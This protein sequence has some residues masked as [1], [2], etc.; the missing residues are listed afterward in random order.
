[1]SVRRIVS[2]SAVW[3]VAVGM[4]ALTPISAMGQTPANS[5]RQIIS[6]VA[7]TKTGKTACSVQVVDLRTGQT[8]YQANPS[9]ALAP[10][11]NMKVLTT[12][13]A[14][15]LLGPDYRYH[16][17]FGL[18]DQSLVVYASGDPSINDPEMV[19]QTNIVD[20]IDRLAEKLTEPI[21]TSATDAQGLPIATTRALPKAIVVDISVFDRQYR[22]PGWPAR[23]L[24][25]WFTAPVTA[26]NINDNCLDLYAGPGADRKGF[27]RI[28]PPCD[29]LKL[30][31]N[32]LPKGNANTTITAR[33][34]KE[35]WSLI[36]SVGVGS[37]PTGP[38]WVVINDPPALFAQLLKHRLNA[39]GVPIA[40]EPTFDRMRQPN[41]EP[42]EGFEPMLEYV[43]PSLADIITR[44]NKNSQNLFAE[45]LFKTVGREFAGKVAPFA[46][47][48][49]ST[50]GLAVKDFLATEVRVPITELEIHDGSGL[51]STNR[52]TAET[53]VGTLKYCLRQ[54]WAKAY[55]NSMAI[56]GKDGTMRR[57]LR[58]TIGDQRVYAKTG[59]I[60]NVTSLSGYVMDRSGEPAAAFS[61]LFNGDLSGVRA[62]H[63]QVCLE[64]V[65]YVDQTAT[66]ARAER[67]GH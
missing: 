8:L 30:N 28:D 22:H 23:D 24:G 48:S 50:G 21:A 15:H 33:W 67:I 10:A 40:T 1:M 16:T 58:R 11:S 43:S 64:L 27:L 54:P 5:I 19:Q 55:I 20:V 3:A 26:M 49:W 17:R 42:T 9:L 6:S 32:Y 7:G 35:E 14:M 62:A 59:Y 66:Q 39:A 44:T 57:R 2:K 60:K 4:G 65:K 29:F 51:S 61:M 38:A 25:Q 18:V 37:R 53:I 34:G 41:G 63:D 12:A 56:A 52:V 47:G 36:V 31:V 46:V 13:A 45:C